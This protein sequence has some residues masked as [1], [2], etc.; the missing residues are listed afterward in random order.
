MSAAGVIIGAM[1]MAPV[2]CAVLLAR[3]LVAMLLGRKP[4]WVRR[5]GFIDKTV[6]PAVHAFYVGAFTF[7]L[8][9]SLGLSGILLW[10]LLQ[11]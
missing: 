3:K 11:N 1:T 9:N 2:A 7:A 4:Y 5:E 10:A 6:Q 8:I